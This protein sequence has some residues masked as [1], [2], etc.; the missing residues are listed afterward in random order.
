MIDQ[1]RTMA[2]FREVVAQGSFRGAAKMLSLSPSVVSHHVS[3]LEQHLGTALLYRSTRRIS[4][5]EDGA[6]LYDATRRMVEAAEA[7]LDAIRNRAQQPM[8]RLRIAVPGAVF[9]APSH[10][11]HLIA[12]ARQYPKVELSISYGDHKLE[13][14]GSKYDAAIRIGWVED[15]RYKIRKLGELDRALVVAPSYLVDR[16]MPKQLDDLSGWD[17]IR[18]SQLPL[19]RQLTGRNGDIPDL[20]P[21]ISV[22]V[23][24]VAALCHMARSGMG[25]AAIPRCLVRSDL[26]EGRLIVLSPDWELNPAPV[27]AVWPD[28]VSPESL[29]VR[30]VRFMA[31]R[32]RGA[33]AKNR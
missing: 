15:S 27:Q 12:F 13:L 16:P 25:V 5:T 4:L 30:F 11:D 2:V 28:N 32:M 1:Y 22:E 21:P 7:G 33:A 8:G 18:L 24:S 3:Q 29:T 20:A 31:E 17:W 26:A 14:V 6:D 9:E 23:D 19:E 10:G